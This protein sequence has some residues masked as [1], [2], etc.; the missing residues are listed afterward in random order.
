M[1]GDK[2]QRYV[3][4][5]TV[6]VVQGHSRMDRG[7]P[8]RP[9]RPAHLPAII[10]PIYF[11]QK[12]SPNDPS[13]LDKPQNSTHNA[14]TMTK[15]GAKK[16]TPYKFDDARKATFLSELERLGSYR[17]ACAAINID[18]TTILRHRKTDDDFAE[19]CEKALERL[20]EKLITVARMLAIDGVIEESFDKTGRVI[21]KRVR[22]D[23][24]ILLRMLASRDPE[25]WSET[26]KIEHD[27]KGSVDH[28]HKGSIKVEELNTE[29]QRAARILLQTDRNLN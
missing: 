9:L 20:T 27:H 29:Q 24:K 15:S 11:F 1:A 13:A 5:W 25:N 17:A 10:F 18:R 21:R 2:V 22:H 3:A 4:V 28:N 12:S 8:A 19:A 14:A 7:P 26:R 16:G 6:S 23:T